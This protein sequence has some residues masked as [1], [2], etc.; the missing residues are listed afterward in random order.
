MDPSYSTSNLTT[1]NASIMI[2]GRPHEN[3]QNDIGLSAFRVMQSVVLQ[4]GNKRR[5]AGFKV[6][7]DF[8][9]MLPSS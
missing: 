3:E 4:K 5:P 1:I 8:R 9:A 2:T 7:L 6:R